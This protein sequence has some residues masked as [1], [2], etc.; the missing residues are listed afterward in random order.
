MRNQKK[1]AAFSTFLKVIAIFIMVP[2]LF[3]LTKFGISSISGSPSKPG[4]PTETNA[5]I[6]TIPSDLLSNA[7]NITLDSWGHP[8][9]ILGNLGIYDIHTEEDAIAVL[10]ACAHIFNLNPDITYK[11]TNHSES[12]LLTRYNFILTYKGI[13]LEDSSA[14]LTV[15]LSNREAQAIEISIL[16]PNLRNALVWQQTESDLNLLVSIL[17]NNLEGVM[18]AVMLISGLLALLFTA[19]HFI[20]Y[21]TPKMRNAYMRGV[22]GMI[23]VRILIGPIY[24]KITIPIVC[25]LIVGIL[26]ALCLY[27]M[28][29]HSRYPLCWERNIATGLGYSCTVIIMHYSL[30]LWAQHLLNTLMGSITYIKEPTNGYFR[31]MNG[32]IIQNTEVVYSTDYLVLLFEVLLIPAVVLALTAWMGICVKRRKDF[33]GI[34]GAG[35]IITG[36]VY[37]TNTLGSRGYIVYTLIGIASLICI[38]LLH[39]MERQ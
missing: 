21:R 28:L 25:P 14:F 33:L 23:I 5:E 17:L 3:T 22:L 12:D 8:E 35:G 11:A 29:K 1:H 38:R 36:I 2:I 27:W 32:S 37:L 39:G 9:Y 18:Y 34:A 15:N 13:V 16:D 26:S 31:L 24:E 30:G 20:R 19:I 6:R 4:S 10:E 7:D